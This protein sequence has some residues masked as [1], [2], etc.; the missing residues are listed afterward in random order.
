M[1]DLVHRK[2]AKSR[3][4]LLQPIELRENFLFS[5]KLSVVE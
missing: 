3:N 2:N 5:S 4:F 1:T